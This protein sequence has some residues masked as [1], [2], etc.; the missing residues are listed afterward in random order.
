MYLIGL[1]YL[2][3]ILKFYVGQAVDVGYII[4][5]GLIPFI[6]IDLIKASVAAFISYKVRKSLNLS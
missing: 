2:F 3:I 1:P 6:G 5:I 4:K